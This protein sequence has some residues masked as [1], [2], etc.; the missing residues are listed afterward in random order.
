MTIHDAVGKLK[1]QAQEQTLGLWERWEAGDITEAQFRA[2]ATTALV[3]QAARGTALADVALAASLTKLTRAVAVTTGDTED[4]TDA[5]TEAV[6]DTLASD[7][8]RKDP[9]G[10]VAVMG[11][12]FA[13]GAMQDA[14]SKGMREQGV[15]FWTRVPNPGACELCVEL[16]DTVLPASVDMYHHKGC[17]C[18]AQ[19][20]EMRN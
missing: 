5:A 9:A 6:D 14:Y 4:H 11:G 8:Y 17:G 10:A 7:P 3:Q 2:L 16:S 13:A 19:P 12:S 18:V 20:V 1:D 15:T